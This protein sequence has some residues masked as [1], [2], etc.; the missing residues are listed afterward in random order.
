M[1]NTYLVTFQRNRKMSVH[2]K[3]CPTC[4]QSF[5]SK[6]KDKKYCSASCRVKA[7]RNKK[8]I[9]QNHPDMAWYHVGELVKLM[10]NPQTAHDAIVTLEALT[11]Y[12]GM[13][14]KD[15]DMHHWHCDTCK[16]TVHK[17]LPEKTDC[18]CDSPQWRKLDTRG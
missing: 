18:L 16:K 11:M 4:S 10:N 15:T 12:I 1:C 6:R 5:L 9:L 13:K 14:T 7:H 8:V 17:H 2:A 3:T